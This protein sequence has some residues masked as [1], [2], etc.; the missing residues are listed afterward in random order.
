MKEE[1]QRKLKEELGKNSQPTRMTLSI[2]ILQP[3]P[4]AEVNIGKQRV[5]PFKN[6]GKTRWFIERIKT[7]LFFDF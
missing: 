5:E 6:R 3:E 7:S 4:F 2:L 1:D